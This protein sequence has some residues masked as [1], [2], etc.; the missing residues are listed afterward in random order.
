[1]CKGILFV[2]MSVYGSVHLSL[3]QATSFPQER[4][5]QRTGILMW[6]LEQ[7]F[8]EGKRMPEN[9]SFLS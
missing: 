1:M 2:Y 8:E 7:W 4:P 6:Q 5:S 9:L 3:S